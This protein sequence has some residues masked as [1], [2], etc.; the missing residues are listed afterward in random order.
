MKWSIVQE[1]KVI[2]IEL[3]ASSLAYF[4]ESTIGRLR[5]VLS[6]KGVEGGHVDEIANTLSSKVGMPIRSRIRWTVGSVCIGKIAHWSDGG[7][8]TEEMEWK[9]KERRMRKV[10]KSLGECRVVDWKR[11]DAE[12]GTE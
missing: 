7:K 5:G 12:R 3:T 6:G 10:R 8:R 11:T 2:E 9:K 1:S 4:G